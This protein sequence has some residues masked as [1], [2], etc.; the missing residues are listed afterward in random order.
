MSSFLERLRGKSGADAEETNRLPPGQVLTRKWPVLSYG[1]TPRLDLATWTFRCFGLV[2]QPM[3]WNWTEFQA[4]Q[5]ASVD[6][7][8]H[9]VTHWTLLDSHFEGVPIRRVLELVRPKA[10]AKYVLVHADPDYTTNVALADLDDEDVLLATRWNGAP[11]EPDHGGP[12]RL[13]IPKLYLW[14]SAKWVRTLEFLDVNVP[15]FW[16]DNG[17]HMH[18]DPWAEE[19]YADQET[20]AMQQMRAEAARRLRRS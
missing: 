19:R 6:C 18:A 8:M 16:E 2:E 15:G 14:K 12:C 9:C 10:E 1:V 4:L 3:T 13:L 20:H 11:L 7:D 5:T 17:Y